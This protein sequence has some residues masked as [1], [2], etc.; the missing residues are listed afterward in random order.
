MSHVR[1]T[2]WLEKDGL[3]NDDVVLARGLTIPEAAKFICGYGNA[4][5]FVCDRPHGT[6]RSVELRQHDCKYKPIVTIGA[7]VPLTDDRDADTRLATEM[8]DIQ[9]F[10]RHNEFWPGR[11][12]TDAEF[13]AR[14]RRIAENRKV[15]ALDRQITTE[16][17]DQLLSQGS[18]ITCCL[19]EDDPTFKKSNDRDGILELLMDLDMAEL[20]VHRNGVTSWIMLIFGED[21]WDVVADHSENLESIIEPIVGPQLPWNKPDAGPQDRGYSVLVLPSPAD[22]DRGDPAAEKA[23]GDFVD[24]MGRLH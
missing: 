11:V 2:L 12:S 18:S 5:P 22:L 6:F 15:R 8:I 23:F 10:E 17:V 3:E 16:L 9:V 4:K 20:H 14:L 1:Y 24:L 21:G 19:R 13:D 7:T